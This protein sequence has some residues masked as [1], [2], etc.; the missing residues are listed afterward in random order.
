MNSKVKAILLSFFLFAPIVTFAQVEDDI[1]DRWVYLGTDNSGDPYYAD[2]KTLTNSTVWIKFETNPKRYLEEHEK[3]RVVKFSYNCGNRTLGSSSGY[4]MDL[5]GKTIDLGDPSQEVDMREV[6]PDTV[7]EN[8]IEQ[9]CNSK[10][11]PASTHFPV[12]YNSTKSQPPI[13]P[14]PASTHFPVGYNY[15]MKFNRAIWVPASTHFPVGYNFP[16]MNSLS[17]AVPASTHFPVGYN[18]TALTPWF[19]RGFLHY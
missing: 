7:G 15:L 9:L 8:I 11:V 13:C 6:R 4:K 16:V 12:G 5:K 19:V 14:V 10:I 2:N 1:A 3:Y 18:A 17:A